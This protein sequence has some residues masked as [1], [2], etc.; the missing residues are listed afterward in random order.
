MCS[1]AGVW[2]LRVEILPGTHRERR[3]RKLKKM[4]DNTHEL[5]N[6]AV[7]GSLETDDADAG[8]GKGDYVH[9]KNGCGSLDG[10]RCGGAAD[11]AAAE[12][13]VRAIVKTKDTEGGVGTATGRA[14]NNSPMLLVEEGMCLTERASGGGYVLLEEGMRLTERALHEV[15]HPVHST[16]C[17]PCWATFPPSRPPSF[18]RCQQQQDPPCFILST[19][20][21]KS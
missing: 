19:K 7:T 3:H 14:S 12:M 20:S 21:G 13:A 9:L 17:Y 10:P 8:E 2:G 4:E 18:F 6:V 5:M 11:H 15:R 1:R 16:A